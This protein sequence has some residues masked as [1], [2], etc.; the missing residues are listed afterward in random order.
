M[1]TGELIQAE[2]EGAEIVDHRGRPAVYDPR[3]KGDY[4]SWVHVTEAGRVMRYK[5]SELTPVYPDPT[6]AEVQAAEPE[7]E[8]PVGLESALDDLALGLET[9]AEALGVAASAVRE[10][11]RHL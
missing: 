6:P 9:A 4:K 3:R 7:P 2:R 10:L 8:L 5:A 11:K 1:N